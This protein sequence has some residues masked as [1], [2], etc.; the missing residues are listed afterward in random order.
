MISPM[1]MMMCMFGG[2]MPP[3]KPRKTMQEAP[4]EA[5]KVTITDIIGKIKNT[6]Y[7]YDE[8]LTI[9]ILTLENGYKVTGMSACVSKANYDRG[10]GEQIA[11]KEA[12]EE[13]WQLEGYLLRQKQFEAGEK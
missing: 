11:Y 7:V 1:S 2:C 3:N 12:L 5:P 4:K 8:L 6:D 13:I 10:R 9:C